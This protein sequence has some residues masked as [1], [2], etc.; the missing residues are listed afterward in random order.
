MAE[1]N[2]S[3]E[4]KGFELLATIPVNGTYILGIYKG[5]LSEFDILIKSVN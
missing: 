1:Q 4:G 5:E 2:I 3:M